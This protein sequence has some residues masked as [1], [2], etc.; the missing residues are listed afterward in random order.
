MGKLKLHDGTQ[1]II[2][3]AFPRKGTATFTTTT[4]AGSGGT[5]TFDEPFSNRAL[6]RKLT[7]TPT[8][9]SVT[10]FTMEFFKSGTFAADK[11]EYKAVTTSG[12]FTDSFPWFHEDETGASEFHLRLTN[13]SVAGT[14][15]TVAL[16]A[17]D[18]A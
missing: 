15:F 9:G 10:D 2:I 8:V 1:F 11:L 4:I 16:T 3:D 5:A 6:V 13:D 17:E 14:T 7:V 18:F 12:T